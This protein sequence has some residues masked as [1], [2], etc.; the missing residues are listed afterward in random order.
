[1]QATVS[2]LGVETSPHF[3]YGYLEVTEGRGK[4]SFPTEASLSGKY[5]RR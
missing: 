1:M 4:G 3:E 2:F 5:N